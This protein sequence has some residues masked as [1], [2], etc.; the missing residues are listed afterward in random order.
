M[1]ENYDVFKYIRMRKHLIVIGKYSFHS[2]RISHL[3]K[4]NCSIKMHT[5]KYSRKNACCFLHFN[6][7]FILVARR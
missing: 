5:T 6:L 7:S 2:V 4:K 1:N 3:T